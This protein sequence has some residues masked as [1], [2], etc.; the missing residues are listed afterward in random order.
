M[1]PSGIE[2]NSAIKALRDIIT[3]I[4]NVRKIRIL[5]QSFIETI[6]VFDEKSNKLF[7]RTDCECLSGS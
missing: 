1:V 6:E 5:L 3:N 4:K 7:T 2:I